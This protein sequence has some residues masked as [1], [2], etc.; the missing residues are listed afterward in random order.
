MEKMEGCVMTKNA[1]VS[2][3]EFLSRT[4][5][6]LASVGL[7]GMATGK[8]H[9]E[10]A[11]QS[12]DQ[13]IYRTLG[14]TG[15]RVPI[16]SMGVMNANNPELIPRSYEIGVRLFDTAMGY[17]GGR[18]EEMVGA[19][20]EKLGVRD[21]VVIV[22]KIPNPA[23]GSRDE[24][25]PHLSDAEIKQKYVENAE[26]CLKR[27]K[28]DYVDAL[29]F[30]NNSTAEDVNNPGV[31]EA[32]AQLKKEGKAKFI[33]I[34]T[35]R[36]QDVVLNEMARMN[37]Y[38][39]VVVAVNFT[40]ADNTALFE[41]LDNAHSKGI[42]LIAMKTQGGG[43]NR[44]D[45]GPINETAAMKYILRNEKITT[46]IPGYTNFEHMEQDFSVAYSLDLTPE[47]KSWLSDK[48]IQMTAGFCQQCESCIG[49]CP[50]GVD[51]PTL[52]RTHMY[53][54]QY[55]NFYQARATLDE[56]PDDIGLSAC[57][58]CTECNARCANSVD[59]PHAIGELKTM[60]A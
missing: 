15:I 28:T 40:M 34:S 8:A 55:A 24:P 16:V 22:T 59:I 48:K 23:R 47:E 4:S 33:G 52:M 51:I 50:N 3:R 26:A 7:A 25:A 54:A 57:A 31:M 13:V 37:F 44:K 17:Q 39:V 35:H 20:I 42:G 10:P 32:L 2:R 60:Y 9:A 27:L 38:D 11:A 1:D 30:H 5:V 43:R 6:G 41:A 19:G 21:D 18:N 36:G 12:G 46:A 49:N 56:I 45:L 58:S 29:L 14:K 53:A